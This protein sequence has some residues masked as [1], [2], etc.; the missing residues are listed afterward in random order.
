MRAGNLINRV[1]FFAKIITRDDYGASV[2]TWPD[3]TIDTRGE[4]RFVGGSKTLS[5]EEKFYSKSI[6]L[7]VRYRSNIVETM[8]VQIDERNDIYSI[9][10]IEPIGRKEGLRLMLEKKNDDS[11]RYL[12]DDTNLEDDTNLI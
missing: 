4:V 1:R 5:N 7:T 2:D 8:R 9:S 12:T 3:V 6:E 10:Y 11:I